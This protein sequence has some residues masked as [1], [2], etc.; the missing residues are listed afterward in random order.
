M[1]PFSDLVHDA[2]F[3]HTRYFYDEDGNYVGESV[4]VTPW[5]ILIGRIWGWTLLIKIILTPV[6]APAY[7]AFV[8]W[9]CNRF[10]KPL[11]KQYPKEWPS[12]RDKLLRKYRWVF[13]MWIFFIGYGFL[14]NWGV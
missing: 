9:F 3:A 4:D 6:L 14:H 1:K 11:L 10:N 12:Y 13:W 8:S 5:M 2:L 7:Y